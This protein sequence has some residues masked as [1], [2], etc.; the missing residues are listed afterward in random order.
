MCVFALP[1]KL[2]ISESLDLK[3]QTY[4]W[5]SEKAKLLKIGGNIEKH[6]NYWG[7]SQGA[8]KI[9]K[10]VPV[11]QSCEFSKGAE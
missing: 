5:Y 8:R 3:V 11:Q 9:G 10:T 7:T 2:L 6:E 1:S 4:L